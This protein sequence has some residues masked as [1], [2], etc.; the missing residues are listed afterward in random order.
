METEDSQA[1]T[2]A[3][4]L[5]QQRLMN[6]VSEETGQLDARFIL[7]RTFCAE[8]GVPVET[9]PSALDMEL[10]PKWEAL[11]NERLFGNG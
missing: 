10:K 1:M 3:E 4:N 7:W 2:T 6:E 5:R 8:H 11:K 9:L